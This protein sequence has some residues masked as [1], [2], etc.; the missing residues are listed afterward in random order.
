MRTGSPGY[1][2]DT[3]EYILSTLDLLS[4]RGDPMRRR[5]NGA[6]SFSSRLRFRCAAIFR[7]GETGLRGNRAVERGA[8]RK[9]CFTNVPNLDSKWRFADISFFSAHLARMLGSSRFSRHKTRSRHDT[10]F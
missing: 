5:C 2:A 8:G 3:S 6:S 10:N 9:S 4:R 7:R 1:A